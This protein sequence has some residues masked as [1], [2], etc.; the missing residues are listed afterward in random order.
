ME[1]TPRALL[2]IVNTKYIDSLRSSN[3]PVLYMAFEFLK[4]SLNSYQTDTR[5]HLRTSTRLT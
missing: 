5:A 4:E 2:G 1:Y 3:Q